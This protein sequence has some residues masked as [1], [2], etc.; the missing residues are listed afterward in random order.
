MLLDHPRKP[1]TQLLPAKM[2]KELTQSDN[3]N[4]HHLTK[5]T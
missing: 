2:L 1:I 4:M 5:V 3:N